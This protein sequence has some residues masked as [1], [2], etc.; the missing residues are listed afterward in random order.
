MTANTNRAKSY[1]NRSNQQGMKVF[2]GLSSYE[3]RKIQEIIKLPNMDLNFREI[4]IR[5]I[6]AMIL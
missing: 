5:N 2:K 4:L 3:R 1:I 6:S